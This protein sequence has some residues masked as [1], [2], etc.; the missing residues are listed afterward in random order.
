[1]P[2]LVAREALFII[3]SEIWTREEFPDQL[4]ETLHVMIFKGKGSQN[5]FQ[6]YRPISL[7]NIATKIITTCTLLL[8]KGDMTKIKPAW[9]FGFTAGKGTGAVDQRNDRR[10][11]RPSD[12]SFP[13]F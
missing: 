8:M 7:F 9:Q 11:R 3:A 13:G 6:G 12:L 10:Q 5:D 2:Y 1:M 4:A